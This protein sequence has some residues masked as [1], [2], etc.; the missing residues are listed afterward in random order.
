VNITGLI[1]AKV[2]GSNEELSLHWQSGFK[3]ISLGPSNENNVTYT[4]L[5]F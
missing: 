5:Y 1:L 4:R 2:I 3:T